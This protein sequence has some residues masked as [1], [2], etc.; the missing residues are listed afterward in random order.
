MAL[1]LTAPERPVG[2]DGSRNMTNRERILALVRSEPGGLTDSEI[3]RR[4]GIEPHQQVNQICRTLAQAGLIQRRSGREGRLINIPTGSL[5]ENVQPDLSRTLD[6]GS[7]Q[8][9]FSRVQSRDTDRM[10]RLSISETL[11][12]LPCS[13]AKR[14]GGGSKDGGRTSVLDSLPHQLAA[15]LNTRRAENAR[16]AK[17]DESTLLPATE[18]YTG[19]LYQEAGDA[20]DVLAREGADNVVISGGYGVVLPFEPIGWYDQQ[21]RK[22]MWPNRLVVRCLGAYADAVGATT[23]VG[24]LSA[25]TQY[26]KVFRQTQWP[27]GVNQVF[28]V[29]PEPKAGAMVKAPRAQGEALKMFSRYH[30]LRPGWTSS[31]GL[32]MQVTWLNSTTGPG[33]KNDV[34]SRENPLIAEKRGST[35]GGQTWRGSCWTHAR[36]NEPNRI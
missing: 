12:V 9:S 4:T 26:S 35:L 10:P 21:F 8:R 1:G 17:I 23:V 7:K 32:A 22:S 5:E 19:N 24:L 3:R 27:D 16:Q 13:G 14:K 36:S 25:T 30:C 34:H 11:F 15:E 18:R 20:F 29:W 6:V 2:D 33:R 28:H 31:D